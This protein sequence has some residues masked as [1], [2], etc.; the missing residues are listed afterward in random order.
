MPLLE[1]ERLARKLAA[2]VNQPPEAAV[3][4]KLA[5]DFVAACRAANLRLR[6]C[7]AMLNSDDVPQALQLAEAAPNLLDLITL[8]EFRESDAWRAYCH[9]NR[10]PAAEPLDSRAVH[11]LN[12]AYTK[13]ISTDDPLY[14]R[15][16]KAVLTKNEDEACGVLRSITRLNPSDTNA[17]AELVR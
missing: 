13:G 1:T 6:Q 8:L 4:L 10:L 7:E 5:E 15:Y 17:A 16:R 12:E 11:Q 14:R 3:A 9:A 2:A